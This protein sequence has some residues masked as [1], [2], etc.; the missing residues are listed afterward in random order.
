MHITLAAALKAALNTVWLRALAAP[1]VACAIV[2]GW[3]AATSAQPAAGHAFDITGT[4]VPAGGGA[5]FAGGGGFQEDHPER[6]AG[7]T[8]VDYTG[9]PLNAAGLARALAYDGSL[10]T[11]P[12]HQCMPHPSMYSF[13]GPGSPQIT[14]EVDANLAVVAYQVAG[15][16]R[17]ADR[18][19]WMDGRPHPPEYAP[20]TWAGF[21]TGRWEGTALVT[22]TTHLKWGWIRRNG[23]AASDLTT[24]RTLYTRRGDVLTITV[25]V[26]DPLYLTEPYVKTID[27]V[28]AARVPTAQFGVLPSD[29]GGRGPYTPCYPTEE[30]LRPPH[31]VPHYLP[32]ANP[33]V[34]EEEERWN[35]PA[36]ATLGGAHTALPEFMSQPAPAA[37]ETT[38]PGPVTI[39]S[40]GTTD[41]PAPGVRSVHVQ[42]NVWMLVGA[43]PNLVMQVGD[44]GVLLVDTGAPGT[45]DAVLAAIREV[46]DKPIRF[47]VNTSAD[48]E[49]VGNN[50]VFG[51]LP[52][53][54]TTGSGRGPT[55]Q[56]VAHSNVLTRMN[57]DE[58]G[59]AAYP[60]SALPTDAY[61]A[62]RR[63][64]FFN[65]EVVQIVHQPSAT[66]DGD[67]LVHFRG[68]DVIAAG[69]LFTTTHFARFDSNRGGRYQGVLSA[70]NAMLDIAVPRFMQ[71]GGTYII[72]GRGRI[73]DEADLVEVRDQVYMIRDRVRELAVTEQMT[74][75]QVRARRPLLDIEARYDRPEWSA[76]LFLEAVYRE[77][78]E[79][80]PAPNP[81][82]TP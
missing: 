71:E 82:P 69:D 79:S 63:D 6:Q 14:A 33:F 76:E 16:F 34:K 35:L 19:I 53:G 73:S 58:P 11:V 31:E 52:G 60:A 18:T 46:T 39:P 20:H 66:T 41:S 70:L 47:I 44:E 27:F 26:T 22:D 61:L 4:W 55:P 50:A 56:I 25:I 38:P 80:T 8:L 3:P 29:T 12:E 2:L 75:D 64:L 36:G 37:E 62:A 45:A 78:S 15:M 13:W 10:L 68:S 72:P 42:G 1:L 24:V 67:S 28:P 59:R 51:V 81:A 48:R 17:R 32:W 43:G 49:R 77:L 74:L 40:T 7:P 21:T 5:T 65:G 23:V 9:I 54:S 57:R 30:V